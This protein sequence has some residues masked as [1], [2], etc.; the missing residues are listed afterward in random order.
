[1]LLQI[2]S[3][4]LATAPF[5]KLQVS[6]ACHG[7][8]AWLDA[9]LVLIF[10]RWRARNAFLASRKRVCW[11]SVG[12]QCGYAGFQAEIPGGQAT[13]SPLHRVSGRVQ[14]VAASCALD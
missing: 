1:M 11:P 6:A 3:E 5:A 7:I 4:Q 13:V 8:W 12:A 14:I 10:E 9:F 2:R